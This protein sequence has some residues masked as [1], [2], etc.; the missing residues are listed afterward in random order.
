[1]VTSELDAQISQAESQLAGVERLLAPVVIDH[2]RYYWTGGKA[3]SHPAIE[4]SVNN[5]SKNAISRIY[6]LMIA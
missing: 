4:F 5:G 1:L 3:Q 6:V 2:P